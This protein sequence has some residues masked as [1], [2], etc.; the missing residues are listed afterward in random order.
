MM[1]KKQKRIVGNTSLSMCKMVIIYVS[2]IKFPQ[3]ETKMRILMQVIYPVST[4]RGRIYEKVR[5]VTEVQAL[6]SVSHW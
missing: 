4:L 5:I 1:E 2:W 6:V 3:A